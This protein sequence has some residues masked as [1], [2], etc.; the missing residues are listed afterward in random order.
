MNEITLLKIGNVWERR[1]TLKLSLRQNKGLYKYHKILDVKIKK[2][3]TKNMKAVWDIQGNGMGKMHCTYENIT[4]IH[5]S[6]TKG[7]IHF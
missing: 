4:F 3:T 5:Y 6:I 7:K 1:S 2:K